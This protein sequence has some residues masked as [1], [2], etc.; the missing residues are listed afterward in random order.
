M[1]KALA[2]QACVSDTVIFIHSIA[3]RCRLI[4]VQLAQTCECRGS[5]FWSGLRFL[6]SS[7]PPPTATGGLLHQLT[8][9][10]SPDQTGSVQAA[11]RKWRCA[12]QPQ[13]IATHVDVPVGNSAFC[14]D[15]TARTANACR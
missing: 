15:C 9:L 14:A 10:H 7:C 13:S 6:A 2:T 3:F 1:P 4:D 12:C 8:H 11:A 5:P